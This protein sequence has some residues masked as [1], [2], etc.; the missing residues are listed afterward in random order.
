MRRRSSHLVAKPLIRH[1]LGILFVLVLGELVLRGL[2]LVPI[3][4]AGF[5]PDPEIGYRVRSGPPDDPSSEFNSIHSDRIIPGKRILFV[6]DSFV[7]GTYPAPDVF[8]ALVEEH[9]RASQIDA[10]VY[11]RGLPA[12][13]PGNY[14]E[15]T[16]VFTSRLKPDVVV[17]TFY[18]GNDI[19]QAYPNSLTR[20]FAGIPITRPGLLTIGPYP[21]DFYLFRAIQ[22]FYRWIL[23]V[24]HQGD[25]IAGIAASTSSRTEE[26][27]RRAASTTPYWSLYLARH[28]MQAMRTRTTS[29]FST[30][31]AEL[32]RIFEALKAAVGDA[33]LLIVLAPA[34]VQID[35]GWRSKVMAYWNLRA[36]DY[37]VTL[38]N[39][40]LSA[41]L[42]EMGIPCLDLLQEFSLREGLPLYNELDIHWNRTGNLV[43]A[44]IIAAWLPEHIFRTERSAH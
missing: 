5:T 41:Q 8:P 21:D 16:R 43:A 37:D 26:R 17:V 1:A 3:A 14:I 11:G 24:V 20:L 12:A 40:V 9:L 35:R 30:S 25:S 33:R 38:P 15:L 31:F 19:E 27:E 4:S 18:M 22:S 10:V 34:R 36:S 32:P 29:R 13:S 2:A 7:F 39:R 23:S 6:G 44:D 42:A 28:E